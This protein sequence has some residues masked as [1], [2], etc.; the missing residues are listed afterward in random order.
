VTCWF[1]AR[2]LDIQRPSREKHGS[3]EAFPGLFDALTSY[4]RLAVMLAGD[5]RSMMA[6]PH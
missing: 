5:A 1:D 3:V 2:G 4:G 6:M